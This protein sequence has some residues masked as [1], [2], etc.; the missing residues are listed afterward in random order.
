MYFIFVSHI[1]RI[2]NIYL[3]KGK[4]NNKITI[5]IIVYSTVV[6][7]LAAILDSKI[8]IFFLSIFLLRKKVGQYFETV[9]VVN[10]F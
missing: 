3:Q 8:L 2:R 10:L 7:F 6:V 5:I 1:R 9:Y 4:V